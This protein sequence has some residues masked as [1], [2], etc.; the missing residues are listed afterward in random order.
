[1]FQSIMEIPNCHVD[2]VKPQYIQ[3]SNPDVLKKSEHETSIFF[4]MIIVL[5][6]EVIPVETEGEIDFQKK[7]IQ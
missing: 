5:L 4:I 6:F 3:K 7:T 1:M 2:P